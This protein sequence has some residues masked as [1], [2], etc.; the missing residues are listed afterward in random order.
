MKNAKSIAT[1]LFVLLTVQIA[2]A[3]Y[4][5]STGRWLSRDPIG[6]PGFQAL[7]AASALPRVG[8]VI[9]LPS[10][11]WIK[12]DSNSEKKEPNRYAFV[13]NNSVNLFDST[14]LSIADVA[15]MYWEFVNT[16][17]NMCKAKK[18]C[19]EIG[20]E[21]N[22]PFTGFW[23]C[24][25]QSEY[26]QTQFDTIKF[27]DGWDIQP[28]YEGGILFHHNSVDIIPLTNPDDPKVHADSWKGCFS[29]TWPA[30]SSQANFSRCW[31]CKDLLNPQPPNSPPVR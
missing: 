23:G 14:G 6:E 10:T 20:W 24:T 27:E 1:V 30:G 2:S 28:S 8:S 21:Q 29:V 3:Y 4:C 15:N 13:A 12:R 9:S 25:K 31:T 17:E 18:C 26:L 7:Q 22:V 16:L 11:R 19:P 5:P